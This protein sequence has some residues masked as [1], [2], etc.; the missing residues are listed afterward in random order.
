MCLRL[1]GSLVLP[2]RSNSSNSS[3]LGVVPCLHA[4][5]LISLAVRGAW[6]C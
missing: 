2:W 1:Y 5:S 3:G 4:R 6:D